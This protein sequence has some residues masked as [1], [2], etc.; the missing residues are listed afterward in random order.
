MYG[1]KPF[2]G[3]ANEKVIGKIEN[4][5]RLA[6]PQNCPPALYLIMME[7]WSY[8]PSKRP[9]FQ[10]LKTRLSYVDILIVFIY[11]V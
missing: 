3:V 9:R 5:E 8:E 11:F 4:G 2:Q 7:C 1:V 10:E 6:L